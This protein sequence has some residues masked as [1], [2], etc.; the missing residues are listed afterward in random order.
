MPA[1][2]RG[3]TG[4]DPADDERRSLCLAAAAAPWV[5]AQAAAPFDPQ[6][7][8]LLEQ[9]VSAAVDDGRIP[10]AVLRIERG[11]QTWQQAFGR[12]AL[13]PA[14]EPL[15][16]KT[17]YDLASLTKVLVTAPVLMR[18][19]EAGALE[20]DRPVRDILPAFDSGA[21]ITVRQ[22]LTHSSGLP[23]S[24]PLTSDWQGRDAALA[25]ACTRTPT[26]APDTFFRYSDVNFI[27]LG[28]IAQRLGGQPLDQLASQWIFGPLGMADTGY[29]PLKRHAA[30]R[31]APTELDGALPLR[32]EVHDPTARRMGGV[33][34]HAGIFG[35]VADVARYG[36][37][38]LNGGTLDGVRV[39]RE[40]SVAR[41]TQL[42]VPPSVPAQRGLG[43]DIDSSYSRPRGKRF[44]VGSYGHTGFTGCVL[45]VNPGTASSHVFLSNRVHPTTRESIVALYEEVGTLVAQALG[46]TERVA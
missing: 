15:D 21:T 33:A 23:A 14:P 24:L 26:H 25:L 42:A 45:W 16:E 29:R 12:K 17:V 9:A 36:R 27:L 22:L 46:V 30:E 31:I 28:E 37:M 13:V 32:G 3:M 43:W 44:P 11:A 39:L 41:M 1:I 4:P 5:G 8:R 7:L 20:L 19:V 18:L 10:G 6:A 38:L 35:T 2:L 40:D 34:G